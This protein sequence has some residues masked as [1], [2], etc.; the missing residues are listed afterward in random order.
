M[1][2]T[3]LI[4]ALQLLLA[5][6][7][8]AIGTMTLCAPA[9][10]DWGVLIWMVSVVALLRLLCASRRTDM[11]M[12]PS[13]VWRGLAAGLF[14][15]WVVVVSSIFANAP[16]INPAALQWADWAVLSGIGTVGFVLGALA[17]KLSS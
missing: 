15:S 3:H 7:G 5:I 11:R 10:H 17:V 9:R 8:L 1:R 6:A 14:M 12:P 13:L 4:Y 2:L 16:P